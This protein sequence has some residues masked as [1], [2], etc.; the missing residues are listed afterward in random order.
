MSLLKNSESLYDR[1][2]KSNSYNEGEEYSIETSKVSN[3]INFG[4]DLLDSNNNFNFSNTVIGRTI[5]GNT[6]ITEIGNQQLTKILKDRAVSNAKTEFAPVINLQNIFNNKPI[7]EKNIDY[8]ITVENGSSNVSDI[9]NRIFGRQSNQNTIQSSSTSQELL[10]NTGKGQKSFI[11]NTINKNL[12]APKYTGLDIEVASNIVKPYST[13]LNRDDSIIEINNNE[14]ISNNKLTDNNLEYGGIQNNKFEVGS[15]TP[16][17]FGNTSLNKDNFN[18]DREDN[19]GVNTGKDFEYFTELKS[20]FGIRKGLLAYTDGLL[21]SLDDNAI[22]RKDGDGKIIAGSK[23]FFNGAADGRTFSKEFQYDRY[24]RAVRYKGN[25]KTYSVIQNFVIPKIHPIIDNNTN[26]INNKDM[27]FSIENLAFRVT[28]NGVVEGNENVSIPLCEVGEN[29]GRLMWFPPYDINLSENV[30]QK[31]ESTE[32]IGRGEP[33]Y[34]YSNTER[35]ASLSFKLIIDYPP[36]IK[37]KTNYNQFTDFFAYGEDNVFTQ[38]TNT[39]SANILLKKKIDLQNNIPKP[40]ER[41]VITCKEVTP[42]KYFFQNNVRIIDLEYESYSTDTDGVLTSTNEIYFGLNEQFET[43]VNNFVQELTVLY[44]S[45]ELK[46][47]ELTG[48]GYASQLFTSDYNDILSRDRANNLINYVDSKFKIETGVSFADAGL[49]TNTVLALGETQ[50]IPAG[51]TANNINLKDVKVDRKAVVSLFF[52]GG[53]EDDFVELTP[54]EIV[55]RNEI[56]EEIIEIDK[57]LNNLRD[58][59]SCIY[60]EQTTFDKHDLSWDRVRNNKFSPMFHSQTPEDFHRRLTFLHQCTRQGLPVSTTILG[61]N[62]NSVFGRPPICILRIGDFF[63]TKII[64]DSM[65]IDY[66]DAPLDLNPEGMGVQYMI[67]DITL[68]MKIIGGMSLATPISR[69]QNAIEFNYYAN[70]TYYNNDI[71][72]FPTSRENDELERKFGGV[73]RSSIPDININK[74]IIYEPLKNNNG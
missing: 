6:P 29:N 10:N 38:K 71:Y 61:K 60:S 42:I 40:R 28:S 49:K 45:D 24:D 68:N 66:T 58:I 35:F 20:S 55:E 31:N 15:K 32:F 56:N 3:L 19:Y 50:A 27:M 30:V 8:R 14:Y 12:Y 39:Q 69:L 59:S 57:A 62:Y 46:H 16:N 48:E 5:D 41:K 18:L 37:G 26:T 67:A 34:T 65:N 54:E 72:Q 73:N 25:D 9:V 52:I 33:V 36:N 64:I 63:N 44:K 23:Q 7:F 22:S 51:A 21:K 70:S 17:E 11:E 2:L 4:V 74:K 47:Y 53:I 13:D 1:T 43:D